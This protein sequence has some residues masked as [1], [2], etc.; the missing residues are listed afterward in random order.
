MA[1][2]LGFKVLKFRKESEKS[3]D[4]MG[5]A[6]ASRAMPKSPH[7]YLTDNFLK[8]NPKNLCLNCGRHIAIVPGNWN[9][10]TFKPR[11]G[12]AVIVGYVHRRPC[13]EYPKDKEGVPNGR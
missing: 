12:K 13:W 7:P 11:F 4:R 3:T 9:Y 8:R 5:S 6:I 2:G 10:L 1:L